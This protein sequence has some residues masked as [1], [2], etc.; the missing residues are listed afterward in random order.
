[1]LEFGQLSPYEMFT[2]MRPRLLGR[3]ADTSAVSLLGQAVS[4]VLDNGSPDSDVRQM[5]A[6]L[7]V[8]RSNAVVGE[9]NN[10][11]EL[12]LTSLLGLLNQNMHNRRVLAAALNPSSKT[13]RGKVLAAIDAGV[14]TPT[15]IGA[16]VGSPTTVVSRVLRQ[17]ADEDLVEPAELA[18]DRR[19]RPYR[20]VEATAEASED[21]DERVEDSSEGDESTAEVPDE[22]A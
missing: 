1:M 11:W 3:P 15:E 21:T 12:P 6:D 10:R 17:L 4:D 14:N 22:Y 20:R 19:Q 9:I 8:E 5:I 16:H 13:L 7:K 18:E 2:A